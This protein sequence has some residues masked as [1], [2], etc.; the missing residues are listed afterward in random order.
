MPRSNPVRRN[1]RS[2]LRDRFAIYD[3]ENE[4]GTPIYVHA[5]TVVVDDTWVAVGSDKLHRR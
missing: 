1:L 4:A 3:L 2:W 5:K